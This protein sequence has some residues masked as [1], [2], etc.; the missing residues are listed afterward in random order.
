MIPMTNKEIIKKLKLASKLM[1]MHGDNPFKIR[2][3][4]TASETI[5][6][7]EDELEKMSFKEILQID[8][9]GKGMAANIEMLNAT[10]SF[11]GL[12]ELLDKTP[13]G[14]IEMLRI[15]GF[16]PKKILTL[17]K[18]AGAETADAVLDL[19]IQGSIAGLKGFAEK[20]QESLKKAVIFL[21]GNRGK[22]RYA[23]VEPLM[24]Q[25]VKTL[26]TIKSIEIA[27]ET[28]DL[29]RKMEVIDTMEFLVATDDF[30]LTRAQIN[31][32]EFLIEK[33]ELSGPFTWYG[34]SAKPKA[35]VKIR[36][37]KIDDFYNQLMLT[38]ASPAHLNSVLSD[39]H[40]IQNHI[41][42]KK[43]KTEKEAFASMN[44][45]FIEPELRE[46]DFEIAQAQSDQLPQLIE[47][48][49][50]KGILHNH[51]TYSDGKH[52]LRQMAE[53]CKDLGYE[54]LG[55]SDHS[56]TAVYAKGLLEFN[57]KKQQKEIIELNKELAP[58][59]I[60]SG[61]ESDILADGSLDY[62]EEILAGFDFIVA[63]VH[64]GLSMDM[65]KATTRL[66][67]AI[68]NPHTTILGH[69]T[70]RL[71]LEREGYPVDHKA[72]IDACADR[73]VVIEINASPF[74]LDID[75]RWVHYA[76]EIGVM[77]SINPDAHSMQGYENMRYGLL[78]GRKAGLTKESTL[79]AM[80]L[81]DISKYFERR[82][83][84]P[85]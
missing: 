72:I 74:R 83:G 84:S 61:I 4:Q 31:K 77:L 46:G 54:Y 25:V 75:W 26:K 33:Q 56:Q 70:G 62:P 40:K 19:C 65:N 13:E 34:T 78:V 41:K 60:F 73:G 82:K 64:S 8:G 32:A 23:T 10:E 36:F 15:S 24:E 81:A 12:N 7:L 22:H 11:D 14:V 17:W 2:S 42:S 18:E 38:T 51:S 45:Q 57:V 85:L 5:D 50:L 58:F 55:I 63:S 3:Y 48:T 30:E 43:F 39:G 47:M 69:M 59:K 16:G 66:I 67:G 79:N 37:C 76:L 80:S 29:R 6:D 35:K 21:I 27:S 28:G 71:L 9:I 49:D 20:S 53:H 44:L 1:E 52:T 68:H